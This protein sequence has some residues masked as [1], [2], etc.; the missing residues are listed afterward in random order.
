MQRESLAILKFLATHA[1]PKTAIAI[2]LGSG[3]PKR[4]TSEAIDKLVNLGF[5]EFRYP[6]AYQV[7]AVGINKIKSLP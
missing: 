4:I 7:T 6:A 1:K 5:V 3:V 2:A